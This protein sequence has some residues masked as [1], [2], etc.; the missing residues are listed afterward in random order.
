MAQIRISKMLSST[1]INNTKHKKTGFQSHSFFSVPHYFWIYS[2][3][4]SEMDLKSKFITS[5]LRA[6]QVNWLVVFIVEAIQIFFSIFLNKFI[7][8][9]LFKEI[10]FI[11]SL[12]SFDSW[13]VLI[14]LLAFFTSFTSFKRGQVK[15][16]TVR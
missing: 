13:V 14:I 6:E 4:N 2:F 5:Q 9:A 3:M 11:Q 1:L 8:E 10:T 7:E 12:I 16:I 15:E